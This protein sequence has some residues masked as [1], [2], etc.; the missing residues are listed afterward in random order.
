MK[1]KLLNEG[2]GVVKTNQQMHSLLKRK[3]KVVSLAALPLLSDTDPATARHINY[4][5]IL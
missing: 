1:F 3:Q 4:I 5:S 2:F